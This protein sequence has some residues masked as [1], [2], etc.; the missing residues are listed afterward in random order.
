VQGVLLDERYG[1]FDSSDQV[2]MDLDAV[3][4]STSIGSGES[5]G[6]D[7]GVWKMLVAALAKEKQT[8]NR[9]YSQ[10]LMG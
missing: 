9:R 3:R 7:P 10:T 1:V 4:D 2:G 5:P 6:L 8:A